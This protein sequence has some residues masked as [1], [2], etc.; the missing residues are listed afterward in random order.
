MW[1]LPRCVTVGRHENGCFC[2]AWMGGS[3][4]GGWVDNA[5]PSPHIPLIRWLKWK[6]P[7][8]EWW[9]NRL[10]G[11]DDL[12]FSALR[13]S[14]AL[15]WR[16]YFWLTTTSY[17]SFYWRELLLS[18]STLFYSTLEWATVPTLVSASLGYL[19]LELT[20]YSAL[21]SRAWSA[22]LYFHCIFYCISTVF[23]T[24]FSTVSYLLYFS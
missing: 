11:F 18:C 9:I 12:M 23:S 2:A 14:T 6:R 19:P 13:W 7:R 4:T 5:P 20:M 3:V 10:H 1:P 22:H 8:W 24:V 21:L 17:S 15:Y 16:S